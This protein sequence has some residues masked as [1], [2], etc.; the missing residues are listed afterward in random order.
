MV[1]I[2]KL[3]GRKVRAIVTDMN[4]PLGMAVGNSLEVKEAVELLSGRIS[5]TDPLY[6][7]CLL[8]G[9]HML[10]AGNLAADEEKAEQMLKDA[11]QDG[12][13]LKKL[14]RMITLQGGDSS[15]LCME[16]IDQM[17]HVKHMVDIC[18]ERD[19]FVTS[20]NAE[21]IGT[22]AQMLGAG[23]ATKEDVI[24][25]AVGLVMKVRCGNLV[26]RGDVLCTMYV[27]DETN[28]S[29]SIALFKE[30]VMISDRV[31]EV[32]PMVYKVITEADLE[33]GT[34]ESL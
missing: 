6:Q 4:Q 23:R 24:D 19:G 25:P 27:N 32:P 22:A 7:V 13:G 10:M 5:P 20:M 31:P 18:S 28:L 29:D 9:K 17:I 33:A 16:K 3:T 1:Q 30:A 11:I 2:G 8:L 15:Y 34:E 14:Q 12:S 21:K 26:R